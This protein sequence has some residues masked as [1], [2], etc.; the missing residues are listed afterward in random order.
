VYLYILVPQESF[1]LVNNPLN[2]RRRYN[3]ALQLASSAP[4]GAAGQSLIGETMASPQQQEQHET[5]PSHPRPPVYK[6]QQHLVASCSET[7]PNGR[8]SVR[9][10]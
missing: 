4:M 2:G 5:V 6:Q 3:T 10:A 7:G 1:I 8:V 9:L